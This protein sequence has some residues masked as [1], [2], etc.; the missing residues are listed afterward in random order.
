MIGDRSDIASRLRAVLPTKWFG[1][2]TPILDTILNGLGAGWEYIYQFQL[3]A[4]QQ[5]RLTTASDLWLDL[6]AG[7]F[8]GGRVRRSTGQSD[9]AFRAVIQRMLLREHATRPAMTSALLTLTGR[10]PRIFEPANTSDTGGYASPRSPGAQ[11]QGG[12]VGYNVGGGWG[13]LALSYQCFIT[14][15]RPVE[16]GV[17]YVSG[18]GMNGAG[19]GGGPIEYANLDLLNGHVSD[20]DILNEITSVAPVGIVAWTNIV[21]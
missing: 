11:P 10:T 12:G 7:D 15:F 21:S 4:E 18:W 1:D 19:Y 6:V 17:A 16:N 13:S 14:A 8:F 3:Y 9:S 2:T 5:T 20:A